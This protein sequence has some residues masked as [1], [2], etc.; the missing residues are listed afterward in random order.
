MMAACMC[1]YVCL[2][3]CV[4]DRERDARSVLD[5]TTRGGQ[6][7]TAGAQVWRLDCS[8][9]SVC[10]HVS[11][12]SSVARACPRALGG[13]VSIPDVDSLHCL[14]CAHLDQ[15]LGFLLSH[16]IHHFSS[17]APLLSPPQ[18]NTVQRGLMAASALS[19]AFMTVNGNRASPT[20]CENNCFP[21]W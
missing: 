7:D 16:R 20:L 8:V 10:V 9:C 17:W 18:P 2:C 14:Y 13:G 21:V 1:A 12:H 11:R 19:D 5:K 15:T 3:V 4:C 6:R